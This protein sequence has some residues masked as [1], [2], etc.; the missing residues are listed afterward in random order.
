MPKAKLIKNN[1]GFHISPKSIQIPSLIKISGGDIFLK[2]ALA[3][4]FLGF[5]KDYLMETGYDLIVDEKSNRQTINNSHH[6]IGP[7]FRWEI[8]G[9]WKTVVDEI[10]L[11][12]SNKRDRYAIDLMNILGI[13]NLLKRSPEKLSGGETAK[14]VIATHLLHNPAFLILDRVLGEL[15][16]S[17]RE[18]LT[19]SLKKILPNSLVIIIDDVISEG[20]DLTVTIKGNRLTWTDCFSMDIMNHETNKIKANALKLDFCKYGTIESSIKMEL[21]EFSVIRLG[22]EVFPKLTHTVCGGYA[23]L[24]SGPNG[25]GKTTL[26][27]GLVG[28]VENTG[29]IALK[30]G[31]KDMNRKKFFSFSPQDP[32]CD[33]TEESIGKELSLA[34]NNKISVPLLLK[35]LRIPKRILEMPLKDDIGVQK[36]TSVIAATIRGRPC[37]LLDEPTLYLG[38]DLSRVAIRAIQQYIGVGGLVLCTSHDTEFITTLSS[39]KP[40]GN[41]I[42]LQHLY[43]I[44]TSQYNS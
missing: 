11:G 30:I 9:F 43:R 4:A 33:I 15:D 17:T 24:V 5:H 12:A 16:I 13:G 31:D 7:Y 40:L 14:I 29:K 20:I 36:L 39:E 8:S 28:L 38:R 19:S 35:N 34:T 32:L 18:R 2:Q 26:L 1:Q 42:P 22:N 3:F 27:E 10:Y 25:C 21:E 44:L 37:C 23:V 41:N 6:Y